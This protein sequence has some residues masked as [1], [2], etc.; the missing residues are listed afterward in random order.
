[1]SRPDLQLVQSIARQLGVAP[2]WLDVGMRS[3]FRGLGG[4]LLGIGLAFIVPKHFKASAIVAVDAPTDLSSLG[5]LANIA[6]QLG[7]QTASGTSP[8]YYAS[9]GD[10][11]DDLSRVLNAR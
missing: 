3:S 2:E 5:N 6:S 10:N 9:F 1:M 8:F 11:T 7:V 4:A